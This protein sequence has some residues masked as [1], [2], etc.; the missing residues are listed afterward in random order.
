M[1]I[2]TVPVSGS[3]ASHPLTSPVLVWV[4]P[5]FLVGTSDLNKERAAGALVETLVVNEP[6]VHCAIVAQQ[7]LSPFS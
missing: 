5:V 2:Q 4:V 6:P 1:L 3:S 7:L